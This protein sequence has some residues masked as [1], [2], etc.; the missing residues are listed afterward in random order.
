[1]SYEIADASIEELSHG[2]EL[3]LWSKGG[4]AEMGSFRLKE[5]TKREGRIG[6]SSSKKWGKLT[7][8]GV[9][10]SKILGR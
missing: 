5:L 10:V 3:I 9:M 7:G 8:G 4:G 2:V 6:K 1:M